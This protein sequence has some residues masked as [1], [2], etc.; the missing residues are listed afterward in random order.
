MKTIKK[1]LAGMSIAAAAVSACS[2]TQ[3]NAA[4]LSFLDAPGAHPYT[5]DAH[6]P[7]THHSDYTVIYG[8]P[9][10]T[11]GNDIITNKALET[12]KK[13]AADHKKSIRVT[14]V[15]YPASYGINGI[16]G[17]GLG[18]HIAVSVRKGRTDML[19]QIYAI[20]KE[21][22]TTKIIL[23]GYSQGAGIAGDI[24]EAIFN[25]KYAGLTPNDID[26]V[27]LI[28]D[29]NKNHTKDLAGAGC[30]GGTR[31]WNSYEYKMKQLCNPLDL[32]CNLPQG[33]KTYFSEAYSG[34]YETNMTLGQAILSSAKLHKDPLI[35]PDYWEFMG[36][37]SGHV[38]YFMD[39]QLTSMFYNSIN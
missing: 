7:V 37:G 17:R 4:P 16:P 32:I 19:R 21:D 12:L 3:S 35:T 27:L 18:D 15:D 24:A 38:L 20:K 6:S 30:L 23:G 25:H 11:D 28:A 39:P 26:S 33:W 13:S 29:P 22:P 5:H 1:I 31:Q 10:L 2:L 9:S 14:P 8:R 36:Y 34:L